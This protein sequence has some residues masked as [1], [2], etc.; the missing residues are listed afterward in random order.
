MEHSLFIEMGMG[1]DLHGQNITKACIRAVE[2]VLHRNSL[3]GMP[4][5]VNGDMGRMRVKVTLAVPADA[6]KVDTEAVKARFPY[7]RISCDVV[8]GG[9]AAPTGH[10]ST[11][12]GD[13]RDAMYIVIAVINVG[14]SE[15]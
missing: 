6:D 3:P 14:Y 12:R 7:G 5:L 11:E 9:L 15:A 4:E 13:T 2:N 1:A 8:A 10:S